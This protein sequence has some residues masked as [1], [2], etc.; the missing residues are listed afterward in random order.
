MSELDGDFLGLYPRLGGRLRVAEETREETLRGLRGG[1][2]LSGLEEF[3]GYLDGLVSV[4][5]E[6]PKLAPVSFLVS[7]LTWD[8]ETAIEATISGYISV[9]ADAMR[10]VLEIE[11]LFLDFA[12]DN[13]RLLEW[14]VADFETLR[15]DYTPA[16]IRRR[17]RAAHQALYDDAI[18]VDYRGHSAALH[19]SPRPLPATSR[20]IRES[21]TERDMGFWE[22]FEH[23]R[24]FLVAA[25]A[26]LSSM[27]SSSDA[28]DLNRL[29]K[30][31]EGWERTQEMQI[32]F[33]ALFE[34]ALRSDAEGGITDPVDGST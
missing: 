22:I 18:D 26:L 20:G 2:R 1:V 16:R 31:R 6:H 4:F 32:L 34:A 23:G 25:S 11:M 12:T 13:S 14:S 19:V 29:P 30:F 10:D 24:R 17:L 5:E 9:A 7:R 33:M 21:H 3:L 8:F 15:R 28:L 27:G